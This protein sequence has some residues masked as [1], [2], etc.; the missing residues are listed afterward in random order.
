MMVPFEFSPYVCWRIGAAWR[1]V[2]QQNFTQ[3]TEEISIKPG[4]GT[5]KPLEIKTKK[6]IQEQV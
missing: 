5:K 4:G 3:S 2:C 6:Q 1:I